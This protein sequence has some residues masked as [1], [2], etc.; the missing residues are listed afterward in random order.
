MF[1]DRKTQLQQHQQR[2]GVVGTG[3]YGREEVV[4]EAS[5]SFP[6]YSLEAVSLLCVC[7][8]FIAGCC[9]CCCMYG[10]MDEPFVS[11][12]CVIM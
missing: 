12:A 5:T 9:C 11:I 1:V 8:L 2:V 4:V 6:I 7:V 3:F 10:C